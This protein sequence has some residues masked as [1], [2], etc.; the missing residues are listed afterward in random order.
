[1]ILKPSKNDAS[2]KLDQYQKIVQKIILQHQNPVTGLFP[3]SPNNEHA[4]IRDN[5]YTILAVWGLS[6]AYKKNADMD[7]DRAKTY[8]LEQ[9]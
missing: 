9:V 6:M 3:A 8:E 4:W 7:E 1:M 2:I 5:V